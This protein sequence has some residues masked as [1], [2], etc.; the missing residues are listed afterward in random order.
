MSGSPA[1]ASASA[2]DAAITLALEALAH[3]A[4]CDALS[5]R[6]LADSGI[7]P[8]DVAPSAADP[9]FLAAVLDFFLSD[10]RSLMDLAAG[11]A[12]APADVA[13]DVTAA[14]RHLPGGLLPHWT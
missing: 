7:S 4:R 14:R 1:S 11:L 8:G 6:F 2:T 9:E 3:L 12:R 5:R 13:A 10:D